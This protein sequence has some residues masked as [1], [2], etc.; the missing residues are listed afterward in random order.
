MACEG[1]GG[2]PEAYGP[3]APV[4]WSLSGA[5]ATKTEVV[6]GRPHPV[7]LACG[8]SVAMAIGGRAEVRSTFYRLA[9]EL[10]HDVRTAARMPGG[11]VQLA[12]MVGAPLRAGPLPDVAGNVVE[13]V[14]VRREGGD[15]RGAG[16]VEEAQRLVRESALPGVGHHLPAAQKGV[17]PRVGRLLQTATCCMLS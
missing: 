14:P 17:P 8:R 5:D 10:R 15:W 3:P 13:P 6:G 11:I 7:A 16:T 4:R 9:V 1:G 12:A 2:D